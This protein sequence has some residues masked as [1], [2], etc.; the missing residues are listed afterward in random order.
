MEKIKNI[1]Y[2]A[3]INAVWFFSVLNIGLYIVHNVF[4]LQLDW[5]VH[6][7]A[8]LDT[9]VIFVYGDEI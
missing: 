9:V 1:F 2:K 3:V 4:Y 7:L 5:W 8:L 6:W